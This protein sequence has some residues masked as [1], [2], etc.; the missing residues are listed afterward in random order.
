MEVNWMIVERTF[1]EKLIAS[2]AM[3]PAMLGDMLEDGQK[4][5]ECS[6]DAITACYLSVRDK[7]EVIAIYKLK[8]LSN[9]VIDMHPMVLPEKRRYGNETIRGVFEWILNNCN[10]SIAKV[11]AQF[12]EGR[13]NIER[14]AI[15]NGFTKEG[16]NRLSFREN[17]KL[18]NQIMVG[19]TRPE[20]AEVL[21]WH[22]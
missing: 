5:E 19:I 14:F 17:N 11:V 2:I 13:K 4:A 21:K 22:R 3:N 6:F 15:H 20:M 1:D 18:I 12:P 7:E 8:Q 16:I 9:T 10:K